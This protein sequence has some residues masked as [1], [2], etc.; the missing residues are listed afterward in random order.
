LKPD[1]EMGITAEAIQFGDEQGGPCQP[2]FVHG[3]CE[4]RA[5]IALATLD[6][7]MLTQELPV[8]T[9]QEFLDRSALGLNPKAALA[10]F[11]CRNP[12]V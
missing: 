11:S 4:H 3:R 2:T 5:L 7:D 12:Q 1:Q 9:V 8:A 6:L 10:L